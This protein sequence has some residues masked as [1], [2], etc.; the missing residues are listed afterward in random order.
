MI[1]KMEE[2]REWKSNNT[3]EDK[4]KYKSLN[5]ELRKETDKTREDWWEKRCDELTEYDKRGRSDLCITR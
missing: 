5:N 2:R 3:E 4:K 1:E